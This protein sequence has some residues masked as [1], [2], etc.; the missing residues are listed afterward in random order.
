GDRRLAPQFARAAR[1]GD[2]GRRLAADGEALL[3]V[4]PTLLAGHA[5]LPS[6]LHGDLWRGNAAATRDGRGAVFD[7]APYYG[8]RETDLAMTELF[9]GFSPDFTAAYR[10][11]WPV[12]AGY[13]V[14]RDLYNLYHMLN[15]FHLFGGAYGDRARRLV[16]RLRAEA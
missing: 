3:A 2:E 11:V 1:R 12:D 15:H 6:L 8:D 14:R 9:G 10:A 16:A 5:P 7:P 13:A 4:L